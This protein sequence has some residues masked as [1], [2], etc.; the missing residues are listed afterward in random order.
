LFEG[1]K[2]GEVYRRLTVQY[3]DVCEWHTGEEVTGVIMRR[4]EIM[5]SVVCVLS[6]WQPAVA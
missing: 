2:A 3:C 4:N 1:K 5:I 6:D